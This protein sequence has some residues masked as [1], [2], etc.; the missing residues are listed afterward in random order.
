MTYLLGN[1]YLH[2]LIQTYISV[3]IPGSN[4]FDLYTYYL[5]IPFLFDLLGQLDCPYSVFKSLIVLLTFFTLF[6]YFSICFI[7]SIN[8][9]PYP[10]NIILWT[11]CDRPTADSV[12]SLCYHPSTVFPFLV[13]YT[14]SSSEFL[15]PLIF[16]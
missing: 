13:P 12:S 3:S 7:L 6:L 11:Q 10:G 15:T 16:I 9:I 2:L 4:L 1:M 5:N 14:V 8:M